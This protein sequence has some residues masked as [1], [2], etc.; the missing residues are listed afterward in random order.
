MEFNR[1]TIEPEGGSPFDVSF[2]P[3]QYSIDK[4]NELAEI[5]IP[6][7]GSPILQFVHGSTRVLNMALYFDTYEQQRDVRRQTDRVYKLLAIDPETHA[8]PICRVSWGAFRFRGVLDKV[9]G[10]FSLFLADGTPVRAELNVSFREYIEVEVL[11]MEN[12]TRSA[13]YRKTRQLREGDSLALI[14]HEEYGDA[15]KWRPIAQ[16]NEIPDPRRLTP[17]QFLIIP[18]IE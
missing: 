9:S 10:T 1:A 16:A 2:N 17:G 3:T 8:P 11:V 13:D 12:P 14:A 6:G 18:A 7:L 4:G 15:R 5:G